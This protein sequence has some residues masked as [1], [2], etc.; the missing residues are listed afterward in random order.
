MISARPIRRAIASYWTGSLRYF[1]DSG[2]RL[3][4]LHRIILNSRMYQLSSQDPS[5]K[6]ALRSA[7]KASVCALS[8]A[9]VDGRG[10]A[11]F[12]RGRYGSASSVSRA[13]RKVPGR[14]IFTFRIFRTIFW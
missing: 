3:K 9:Q 1:A 2:F 10:A 6:D 7:R 4:A 5:R 12:D 8:A 13:I 14:W 11:R